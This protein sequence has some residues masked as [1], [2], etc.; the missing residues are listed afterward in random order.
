MLPLAHIFNLSILQR[1]LLTSLKNA[2]LF[3]CTNL[4]ILVFVVVT[5]HPNSL[6]YLLPKYLE[7]ASKV[8]YYIS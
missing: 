7:I 5:Y 2:L 4:V 8:E 1:V 3:L 6:S